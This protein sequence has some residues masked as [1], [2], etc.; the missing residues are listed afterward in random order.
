MFYWERTGLMWRYRGCYCL[1]AAGY[2]VEGRS[3][4]D[5][6]VQEGGCAGMLRY[7]VID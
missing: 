6:D 7:P 1:D 2:R 4:G 3:E 5:P